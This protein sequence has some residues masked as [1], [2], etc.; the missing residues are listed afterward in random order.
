MWALV[1]GAGLCVKVKCPQDGKTLKKN[2]IRW[3]SKKFPQD[4]WVNKHII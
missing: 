3:T 2:T 1:T 4:K